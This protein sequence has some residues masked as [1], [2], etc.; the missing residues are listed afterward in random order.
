MKLSVIRQKCLD[1]CGT[2]KEVKWC[3]T[4][5]C[6]LWKHRMNQSFEGLRRERPWLA[7]P[8]LHKKAAAVQGF[9]ELA[10]EGVSGALITQAS[11]ENARLGRFLPAY[12][13]SRDGR[14]FPQED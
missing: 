7:D 12:A 13:L 2:A 10:T 6:P 5:G 9:R 3:T 11:E 8:L 14:P 4:Y 1:C